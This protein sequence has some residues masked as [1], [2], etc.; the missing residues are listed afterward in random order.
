MEALIK[1]L[2]WLRRASQQVG[3][4][5]MM[6]PVAGADPQYRERVYCYELY[7]QWRCQWP[8]RFPYA[9]SGET[10][11]RKHAHVRGKYLD[12]IKPDFLVHE[13][14]NMDPDSNLLAVEVKAANAK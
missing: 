10:D 11:K 5:Y 9:L 2:D 4:E 3:E 8:T 13:P 6:L 12:D 14:G 7:H 1:V